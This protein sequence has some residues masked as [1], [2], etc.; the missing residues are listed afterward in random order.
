MTC[1]LAG[2][3]IDEN[4]A[5]IVA[6]LVALGTI[7]GL[8]FAASAARWIFPILAL[9]FATRAFS[10]PRWSFLGKYAGWLLRSLKISPRLV[11]AGPKR[12]AARV[13]LLFTFTLTVLALLGL[14]S[15]VRIVGAVLLL[16][17]LLES[18]AGFCVG[19]QLWSAWYAVQE[20][21]GRSGKTELP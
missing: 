19:C 5:R 15:A 16:C 4:G 13:G 3:R 1:P 7:F 17:A 9:D 10:R 18:L 2:Y 20:R 12:F 11:D 8:I 21:L 6:G 14:S